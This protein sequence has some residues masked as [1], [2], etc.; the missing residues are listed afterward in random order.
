MSPTPSP[1]SGSTLL[2]KLKAGTNTFRYDA[3]YWT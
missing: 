3:S 1:T 2:M